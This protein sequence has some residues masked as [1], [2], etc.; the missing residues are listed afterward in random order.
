[1]I[2]K[3]FGNIGQLFALHQILSLSIESRLTSWPIVQL[4]DVFL[5]TVGGEICKKKKKIFFKTLD[6]LQNKYTKK[7]KKKKRPRSLSLTRTLS[8]ITIFPIKSFP[9]KGKRILCSTIS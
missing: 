9:P 1:M 6:Y 7:K 3:I 4:G 8:T 5:N 2:S